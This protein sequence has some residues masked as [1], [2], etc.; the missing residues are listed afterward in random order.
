M[1]DALLLQKND[2]RVTA[3]IASLEDDALP[4]GDV[5][6]SVS[7]SSL[8]YKDALAVTGR[9]RIVR[10]DYPFVPGIDLAGTVEE[11]TNEAFPPGTQVICTG[12][13]LGEEHWGGYARRQRLSSQWLV[14]LPDSMSAFAAMAL[15]TAGLTAMLSVVSLQEHSVHPE[16]G[17]IVVTGASGGVGSI[18]VLLLARLGYSVVAST[19]SADAHGMLRGLGAASIIEREELSAGPA[20][21]LDRSRWAGAV[22]VVG[23]STLATILSAVSRHGCVASCGLAGSP[24]LNTTV[25]PFILRGVNLL[26]IDS[27]TCPMPRRRAAWHRLGELVSEDD[28]HAM[29]RTISLDEVPAHSADLLEN[30]VRGRL[31]VDLGSH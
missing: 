25:Y 28:A 24:E 27:N 4:E 18:A 2:G 1:F 6:V 19:G 21:P 14:R 3:G 7:Y 29:A 30:R 15:G 23:G 13:G 31:V 8:N 10:A 26:G 17:E 12:W 5:L 9:G 20:K 16:M 22:D 11:S